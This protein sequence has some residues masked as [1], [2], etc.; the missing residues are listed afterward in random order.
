MKVYQCSLFF[1]FAIVEGEDYNIANPLVTFPDTSTVGSTACAT[2]N[3]TDDSILELDQMFTV[4]LSTSDPP[5]VTLSLPSTT[6]TVT[7]EDNDSKSNFEWI[8]HR[9]V[10]SLYQPMVHE[11]A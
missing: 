5:G 10:L 4:G 8:I 7:I 1:L 11:L 9:K 6:A 3:I 2:F